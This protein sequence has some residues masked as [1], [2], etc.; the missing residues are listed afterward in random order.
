MAAI[1]AEHLAHWR[2][3]GYVLVENLLGP[4]ELAA[5]RSDIAA[6]MPDWEAYAAAPERYEALLGP[7]RWPVAEFPFGG[8]GLNHV[9]LHPELVAFARQVLV[10]GDVALSHARLRG[11]YAGAGD[12]EQALHVDYSNNTLAYPACDDEIVDVP[13]IV[14]YTDVA[15]DLGPTYVLSK[16]HGDRYLPHA[17][18]RFLSRHEHPEAY[19]NSVPATVPAGSALVYSMRTFHRGS[20][21]RATE[22]VRFSH[23]MSLRRADCRWAGQVL[24][25]LAGD[26]PRMHRFL[27]SATPAQR[28]I[29]GFPPVGDPYWNADSLAGVAARYPGMDLTP[30]RRAADTG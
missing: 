23:H 26:S 9:T 28:E 3:H 10:T 19:E 4:A 7:D 20:A 13:F 18:H 29:V 11:K 1:T 2:R 25:N 22:G 6:Y 8:A 15:L 30:Y 5:A 12:H 17:A 21:L 27:E 14:Y 16:Q 24:F